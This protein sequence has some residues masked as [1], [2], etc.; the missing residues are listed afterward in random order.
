[1]TS[2]QVLLLVGI[3]SAIVGIISA[4]SALA[5]ILGGTALGWILNRRTQIREEKRAAFVELLSAMNDCQHGA[6]RMG[7]AITI[8]N[9]VEKLRQVELMDAGIRRVDTAHSVAALAL[10]RRHY[11]TLNEAVAACLIEYQNVIAHKDQR[12]VI[13]KAWKAVLD[14]AQQELGTPP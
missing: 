8:N 5:G 13:P 10:S 2:T 7:A 14:L 1:M 3:I 6:R 4:G 11:E 12:S 9:D